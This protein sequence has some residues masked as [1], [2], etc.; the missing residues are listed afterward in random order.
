MSAWR[1]VFGWTAIVDCATKVEKCRFSIYK[2]LLVNCIR[3]TNGGSRSS[4]TCATYSLR[5]L[6]PRSFTLFYRVPFTQPPPLSPSFWRLSLTNFSSWVIEFSGAHAANTHG[7]FFLCLCVCVTPWRSTFCHVLSSTFMN[8]RWKAGQRCVF[9]NSVE[10]LSVL[11][12][13]FYGKY[14]Q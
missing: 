6:L 5:P 11:A 2:R 7:A 14:L 10:S 4:Q 13:L 9:P 3:E 1:Y 12:S 8:A